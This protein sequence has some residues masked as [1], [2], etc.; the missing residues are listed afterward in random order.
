MF[1]IILDTDIGC[2]FRD[3]AQVTFAQEEALNKLDGKTALVSG[4]AAGTGR[5][6]ALLFAAEGA[7]VVGCDLD[8][9]GS[10]ETAA[11]ARRRGHR[12]ESIGPVDLSGREQS[13]TW[14]AAAVAQTGAI[15]VLCNNAARF[16]F[17]SIGTV[18]G[19]EFDYTIANELGTV[20]WPTQA[21]WPHLVESRGSVVNIGSIAGLAGSSS[22]PKAIHSAAKAAVL[23]LTRQLAAEGAR[24][25][26][27]VNVLSPGVIETDASADLVAQGADGPLGP[28][29][30]Q[31]ALGGPGTVDD[32]AAGALYLASADSRFTTGQDIVLDGGAT[33]LR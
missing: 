32:V 10:E 28:M 21:A 25:G 5:A 7:V 8:A 18:T 9:D 19:E 30:A 27:R 20:F 16:H 24:D 13:E 4:T 26:V 22:T 15:D 2:G 6:I 31:I 3:A 11:E 1:M 23:G 29:L 17:G 14:I 33:A 12:M